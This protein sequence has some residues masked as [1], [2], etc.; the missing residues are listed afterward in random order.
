MPQVWF[1]TLHPICH[2]C[3]LTLCILYTTSMVLFSI[4]HKCDLTLWI[5]Y[6]TI[7]VLFS[8]CHKCDLTLWIVYTTSMVLFSICHKCGLT[9]WILCICHKYGRETVKMT[10]LYTLP[11]ARTFILFFVNYRIYIFVYLFFSNI[12]IWMNLQKL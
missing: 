2:K 12:H 11:G 6:T 8:I 3:G 1:N 5:V 4:C 10:S 7:V 9:L